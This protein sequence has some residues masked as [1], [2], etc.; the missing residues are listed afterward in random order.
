MMLITLISSDTVGVVFSMATSY[1]NAVKARCTYH[2]G[3]H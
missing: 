2:V 1:S 3:H